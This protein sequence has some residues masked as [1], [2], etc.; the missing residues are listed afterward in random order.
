MS[1]RKQPPIGALR[2]RVRIETPQDVSDDGGGCVR[3][4]VSGGTYWAVIETLAARQ[5]DVAAGL[6][7][8]IT[9][10]ITFRAGVPVP[11]GARLDFQGRKFRI[12]ARHDPDEKRCRLV[13]LCREEQL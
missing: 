10:R 3:Q 9:H 2:H 11:L 13:C 6:R 12:E 4:W 5:E 8:V 7:E 1:A